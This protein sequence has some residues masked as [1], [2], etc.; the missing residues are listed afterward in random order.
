[1]MGPG[2]TLLTWTPSLMPCSEKALAKA[3]IAALIV[4]TAA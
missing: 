2:N 4:A 1:M 3:M